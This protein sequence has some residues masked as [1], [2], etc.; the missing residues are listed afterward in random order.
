MRSGDE[1]QEKRD[2]RRIRDQLVDVR[3][4]KDE[5]A[6]ASCFI[7]EIQRNLDVAQKKSYEAEQ[8]LYRILWEYI[9]AFDKERER[10][11]II[12]T[13]LWQLMQSRD[14]KNLNLDKDVLEILTNMKQTDG[15]EAARTRRFWAQD[16]DEDQ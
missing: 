14:T 10:P 6:E 7:E 3:K 13:K 8:T 1:K 9:E 12:M 15:C 4:R 2:R 16:E 5:E 11:K